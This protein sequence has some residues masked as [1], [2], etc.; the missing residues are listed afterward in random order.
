MEDHPAQEGGTMADEVMTK[1][2][3]ADYLKISLPTLERRI[4]AGVIPVVKFG[5]RVLLRKAA[6]DQVLRDH[7]RTHAPE[8]HRSNG[9][10][11][12]G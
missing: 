6:L 12:A 3:A 5:R 10:A 8:A 7:E 4:R 1:Q 2:E 9:A 11:Q